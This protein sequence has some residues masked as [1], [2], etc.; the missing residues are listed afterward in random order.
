MENNATHV[1]FH[2]LEYQALQLIQTLIYPSTPALL[3]DGLIALQFENH[4]SY[5]T[6][7]DRCNFDSCGFG[8]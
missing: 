5:E 1:F 8:N 2:R 4:F 7:D 3:H 6:F